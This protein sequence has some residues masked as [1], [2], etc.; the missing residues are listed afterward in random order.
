M[1]IKTILTAAVSLAIFL[2]AGETRI[3]AQGALSKVIEKIAAE[4]PLNT[5]SWGM[6]AV[7]GKGK[8]L[9]EYN[10]SAKM[11]PAS[12]MKLITTGCALHSL[13]AD[14]RFP[15]S[16]AY[17]GEI[18]DGTLRG[19]IYIVGGGD[20]TIGA[21]DSIAMKADGLFWKWKSA[22]KAAGITAVEGR[23]IGDGRLSSSDDKIF[24]THIRNVLND[25]SLFTIRK[26]VTAGADTA[27]LEPEGE[28]DGKDYFYYEK[29]RAVHRGS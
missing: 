3:N 25:D 24:D 17:S 22:M 6:K 11:T 4:A 26:E 9:A 14:F 12:N 27:T 21:A 2:I 7:D 10:P 29:I 18:V 5:A 19:D 28:G 13:G 16:I 8:V 20:P 1:K 15:T 23:I